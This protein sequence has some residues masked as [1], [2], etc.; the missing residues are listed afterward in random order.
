MKRRLLIAFYTLLYWGAF[1]A[2]CGLES[3]YWSV[4]TVH[5]KKCHEENHSYISSTQCSTK[6]CPGGWTCDHVPFPEP[7]CCEHENQCTADWK[8]AFD[9]T[10]VL[11]DLKNDQEVFKHVHC[12]DI[13]C[14]F[15]MWWICNQP[16][17]NM[18][19]YKNQFY[20]FQHESGLADISFVVIFG[21]FVGIL[22]CIGTYEA[23]NRP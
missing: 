1:F 23:Y 5:V 16:D 11:Y 9:H 7:V 13:E 20:Y 4:I 6:P 10:V 15:L 19:V 12:H 8:I 22:F 3:T 2:Y 17:I 14:N 21:L 18:N